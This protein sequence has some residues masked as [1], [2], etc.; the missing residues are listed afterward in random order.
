MVI[1][2]HNLRKAKNIM[3]LTKREAKVLE[4]ESI[5]A[6]YRAEHAPIEM[7]CAEAKI[8]IN[9]DRLKMNLE[10]DEVFV[11]PDRFC[12]PSELY[13]IMGSDEDSPQK[14]FAYKKINLK[15]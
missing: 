10:D 13:S 1:D 8:S 4:L 15:N 2:L 11:E 9:N 7:R 14:V 3:I 12:F 6:K 5:I